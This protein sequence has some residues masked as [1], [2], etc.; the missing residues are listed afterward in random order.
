MFESTLSKRAANGT[1]AQYLFLT[2]RSANASK[3]AFASPAMRREPAQMSGSGHFSRYVGD[4]PPLFSFGRASLPLESCQ[5][6]ICNHKVVLRVFLTGIV[7]Q[8]RQALNLNL[9]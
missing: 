1:Q 6:S 7:A 3:I 5:K 2:V 4:R 8:S 9:G